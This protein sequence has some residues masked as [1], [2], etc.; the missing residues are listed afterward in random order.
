M[1]AEGDNIPV[2]GSIIGIVLRQPDNLTI[3][4]VIQRPICILVGHIIVEITC[5]GASRVEY[6][7][8]KVAA[9]IIVE[10]ILQRY[11]Q[12]TVDGLVK[13]DCA[14]KH[15]THL[16]GEDNRA[17]ARIEVG[18]CGVT[19]INLNIAAV[20]HR[21]TLLET[22]SVNQAAIAHLS[23]QE[24]LLGER[25]I[26]ITIEGDIAACIAVRRRVANYYRADT[27]GAFGHELLHCCKVADS[28][29]I[30]VGLHP[31]VVE[32]LRLQPFYHVAA[33]RQV[34][35]RC[36]LVGAV[37]AI[38]ELHIDG[39]ARGTPADDGSRAARL[40][41][42]TE[43]IDTDLGA[44]VFEAAHVDEVAIVSDVASH[45][46]V[47]AHRHLV[48][49]GIDTRRI[50]HQTEVSVHRR[51]EQRVDKGIIAPIVLGCE[52]NIIA[53]GI[54]AFHS[55]ILH[56]VKI[57]L[58][59][60]GGGQ[61]SVAPDDAIDDGIVVVIRAVFADTH[62][63]RAAGRRVVHDVAADESRPVSTHGT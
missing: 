58:R 60:R 2:V 57:R 33:A 7:K 17:T 53:A 61:A 3:C 50:L 40:C 47:A 24:Y 5:I 9:S 10:R 16:R 37:D 4:I 8:H 23:L 62:D 39:A 45:I 46:L 32:R 15:Q 59:C 41:V 28:L 20:V 29:F 27:L 12:P 56:R 26:V 44:V 48:R 25:I 18:E 43:G 63:L 30:T 38:I 52:G 14:V 21:T 49:A 6:G 51:G 54:A 11:R 22:D 13:T 36:P 1:L 31:V 35:D 19:H 55:T 42:Q 34:V